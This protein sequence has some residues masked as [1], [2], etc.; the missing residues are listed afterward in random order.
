M[1]QIL[2]K[3]NIL[4]NYACSKS[5]KNTTSLFKVYLNISAIHNSTQNHI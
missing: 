4:F 1:K 2:E 3:F 5:K